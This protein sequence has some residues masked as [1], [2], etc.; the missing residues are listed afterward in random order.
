MTTR[1]A[2]ER[3][4]PLEAFGV[5]RDH[6]RHGSPD[7]I[8]SH[9]DELTPR[10]YGGIDAELS[11]SRAASEASWRFM[12]S[13]HGKPG[14]VPPSEAAEFALALCG[15][16]DAAAAF[17]SDRSTGAHDTAELIG[18]RTKRMLV[19]QGPE[20]GPTL[21]AL[22]ASKGYLSTKAR[23]LSLSADPVAAGNDALEEARRFFASLALVLDEAAL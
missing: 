19:S 7:E 2:Y 13:Q 14:A 9:I 6:F 18:T 3:I 22:V 15:R 21:A 10:S 1:P 17:V 11:M 23:L 16:L 20:L 5:L 4:D 12:L 8:I